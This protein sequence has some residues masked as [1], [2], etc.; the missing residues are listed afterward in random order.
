VIPTAQ[1][2]RVN[3]ISLDTR[4]LG[5]D[6]EITNATQQLVPRR[7]AVVVAR[8]SGSTGRRVLFELYDAQ[9]K[10]LSFGASL[11]DANGKQL[12]IADPNGNALALVEQDQGT[13]IIK[14]GEQQ[15]NATYALPPQNKALNYERQ[16]L[17][18]TP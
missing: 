16:A 17:V 5:G 7:G 4:D 15:C 18:C 13:L 8:Y 14:W 3:W 6:V 10:P 11:E 9:H 12:A 1:P 2:Y